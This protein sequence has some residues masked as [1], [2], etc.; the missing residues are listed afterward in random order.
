MNP[1]LVPVLL[2]LI[3]AALP[4]GAQSTSS[5]SDTSG[6]ASF[7]AVGPGNASSRTNPAVAPGEPDI[8][9]PEV[10]LKVEDLSVEKV[11]AQLPPTEDM[12]PPVRPVPT[13]SE[14]ELAVGE[15]PIPAAAVEAEGA[16]GPSNDR[17]LSSEVQLGAGSLKAISGSVVLKTLGPDPRFSLQFHHETLDGFG[18]HD[19]GSGFNS[20]D[21]SLGGGL[22]FR[23]LGVD[24]GLSGSFK[25]DE[26]GL[27]GMGG[28]G[29]AYTSALSRDISGT[30]TFSG[31]PTD[32]L[33][34]TLDARGSVDSTTMQGTTPLSATGLLLAP[35]LSAQAHFGGIRFGLDTH[36]WY[37]D[38]SYL[39]SGQSQLHRVQLDADFGFDLPAT[40]VVQ[41]A[42]GWFWNSAGLSLFPFSLAVTGTPMEAL[43]L[44]LEGGYKVVPYGM[45]DMLSASL[46]T[47]PSSLADDRGWY[48]NSSVQLSLTRDLAATVNAAFML[49]DAM[50]FG[51]TTLDA[52]T[53]LFPVTQS[54]GVELSTNAG[55]RWGISQAFSLSAGWSHEFKDRPFF[56]PIDAITAGLIALEA[57]GRFG[58]SLT[59][60]A[61]PIA[62]GTLQ[63]PLVHIS[64]FWKII[65]A[66]KFQ[67]D[68]DDL[69]GPLIGSR[70]SISS[71]TYIT[72]GFRIIGSLSMSL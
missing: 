70:W 22:K 21:D 58:G 17:L 59:V 55:L 71:G 49:H 10:I 54:S 11:E 56:T 44:S 7:V 63:Q 41:A 46:L 26:T 68:G 69:L 53:G 27:Q 19:P 42:V 47:L 2:A 1:R 8:I 38:E 31:A 18:G 14:G 48:A 13:L 36:Y 33:T 67:V 12:L 51:S 62:D 32:W 25:E 43:T 35:V 3:L 64:G 61:G 6:A 5:A 60:S 50:P 65:D 20:R 4:S 16:V 57:N 45:Q 24:T 15:P 34:L 37:R 28:P 39:S 29:P 23:L 30:G 40:F 9:M 52:Q 66:V 72:P